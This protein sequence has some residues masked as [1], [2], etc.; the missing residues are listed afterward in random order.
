MVARDF[1]GDGKLDL[2]ISDGTTADIVVFLGNGD[3]TFQNPGPP[4]SGFNDVLFTASDVNGDGKPDLVV[5]TTFVAVFLGNG[6][7]TFTL[8]DSYLASA[9]GRPIFVADFNGDG[10]P[11]QDLARTLP[12]GTRDGGFQ[13]HT[14]PSPNKTGF[15]PPMATGELNVDRN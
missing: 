5:G 3:G 11:D 9:L 10:E 15:C 13:G 4:I 7:G 2:I 1:N 8:K 12:L 6:N 14:A